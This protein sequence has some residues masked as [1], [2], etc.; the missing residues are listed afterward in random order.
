[1]NKKQIGI[2]ITLLALIIVA[3]I[4]AT[5]VQSP[6]YVNTDDS[7]TSAISLNDESKSQS[8]E[9]YFIETRLTREQ[10]TQSTLQSLKDMVDDANAPEESRTTAS[11]KYNEIAATNLNETK[12]EAQVKAKGYEDA[13]CIINEEKASII[14]KS[15]EEITDKQAKEIQEIVM[16]VADIANVDIQVKE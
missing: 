7:G 6:L 5:K 11:E 12:I 9:D 10:S 3:G 14:L 16:S 8:T 1:M 4:A 2:V 13:L 15:D